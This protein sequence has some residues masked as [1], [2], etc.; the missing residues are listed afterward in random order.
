MGLESGFLV[1]IEALIREIPD[2]PIPGILFRDITPLLK[3]KQGFKGAIDLF[4]D[5][6]KDAGVDYVIGIESRGY[7]FAAPLAYALGAGF[8]P[9]RKPGKL[10][11][12]KYSESYDLEYGTNSLEIHADALSQGDRVVVVDDLLATG[13]T[14]AAT[15]RL[16]ERLGADVI[17]YAF[18]I[19]LAALH[20]RDALSGA[21]VVSFV[22]Y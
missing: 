5:R 2:F 16:L 1:D 15:G 21:E 17:A 3:D 8:I 4:V 12:D 18:M 22:S 6:F 7:V 20:G 13:G 11:F 9:V 10:P 19:E 14:A